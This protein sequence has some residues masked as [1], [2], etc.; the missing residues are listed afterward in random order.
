MP[1][2]LAKFLFAIYDEPILADFTTTGEGRKHRFWRCWEIFC[3][4]SKKFLSSFYSGM[5]FNFQ[6]SGCIQEC[7]QKNQNS[8]RKKITGY[9]TFTTWTMI[10]SKL[11]STNQNFCYTLDKAQLQV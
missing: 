10:N 9:V 11:A 6:F 1:K 3:F 4:P 7:Y 5:F 2:K 8:R